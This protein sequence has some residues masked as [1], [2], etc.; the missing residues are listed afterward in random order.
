[1]TDHLIPNCAIE[2][3]TEAGSAGK[4]YEHALVQK[5]PNLANRRTKNNHI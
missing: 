3:G 4:L 5:F 2:I 1:M